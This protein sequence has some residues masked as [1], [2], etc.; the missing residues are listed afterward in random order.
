MTW[1]AVSLRC[2]IIVLFPVVSVCVRAVYLCVH[3]RVCTRVQVCH[4]GNTYIYIGSRMAL[5]Q[6]TY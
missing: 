4:V 1:P 5:I 2:D 3:M 6:S